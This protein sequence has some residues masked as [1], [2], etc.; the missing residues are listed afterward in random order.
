MRRWNRKSADTFTGEAQLEPMRRG[1]DS[2]GEAKLE[3]LADNPRF[4]RS[5][6]SALL[7]GA[8]E[9]GFHDEKMRRRF[10]RLGAHDQSDKDMG[11]AHDDD[12]LAHLSCTHVIKATS[13]PGTSRKALHNTICCATCV[14]LRCRLLYFEK[15]RTGCT[16]V[17]M[18]DTS[19]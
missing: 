19:P 7:K 3:Q 5:R 2:R 11:T 1:G 18:A 17:P 4:K 6:T 9:S 10:L 14:R 15:L 16:V 12:T 8:D 13:S